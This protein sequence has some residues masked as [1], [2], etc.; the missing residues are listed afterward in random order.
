[1]IK[2]EH[3]QRYSATLCNSKREA[4]K[5]R[6]VICYHFILHNRDLDTKS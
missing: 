6:D 1:M 4:L 5:S 3:I 2:T